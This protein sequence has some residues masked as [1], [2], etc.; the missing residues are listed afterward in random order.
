MRPKLFLKD[1]NDVSKICLEM[2]YFKGKVRVIFLT[3][4][5]CQLLFLVIGTKKFKVIHNQRG[6]KS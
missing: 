1:L 5:V 3:L 2:F 6:E 4:S